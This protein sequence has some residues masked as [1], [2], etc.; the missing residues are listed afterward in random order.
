[1]QI[2]AF[3]CNDINIKV[4]EAEEMKEAKEKQMLL[5]ILTSNGIESK[6]AEY[7]AKYYI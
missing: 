4:A 6:E 5:K 1:M 7:F 2:S 3:K